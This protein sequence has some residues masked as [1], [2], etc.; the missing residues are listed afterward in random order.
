[1]SN[2]EAAGLEKLTAVLLQ[3]VDRVGERLSA[4]PLTRP[5]GPG[6]DQAAGV[7]GEH[8]PADRWDRTGDTVTVDE[9][10]RIAIWP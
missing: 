8:R 6:D 5:R 1:M 10:E 7:S 2:V 3:S 9:I 4:P